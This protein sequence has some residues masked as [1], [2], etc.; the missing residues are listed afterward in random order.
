MDYCC[1]RIASRW[2]PQSNSSSGP[3]RVAGRRPGPLRRILARGNPDEPEE[4]A[5]LSYCLQSFMCMCARQIQ[6][7]R[8][9]FVSVTARP[10]DEDRV[11]DKLL[12]PPE[13]L[14]RLASNRDAVGQ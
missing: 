5:V 14:I 9:C 6:D 2:P 7:G 1:R 12:E 11:S 10:L 3:H 13:S 8:G 4:I